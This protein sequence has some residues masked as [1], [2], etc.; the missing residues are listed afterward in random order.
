MAEQSKTGKSVAFVTLGCAKNEVDSEAM[1]SRLLAA[2]YE[3]AVSAEE[4][5]VVIVNTCS[6]IQA[7]T[8]ESI[9]AILEVAGFDSVVSGEAHLVVAGC[10]P[11]RYG[12][13]LADELVEASDFV[14]CADEGSIVET[15]DNLCGIDRI[16]GERRAI[17]SSRGV[18]SGV[19]AYVK[20]SDGC[21]RFCAY[22]T[23]PYIRG[24]YHSFTENEIDSEVQQ[25]VDSGTREIVL[26]AQDTGRWGQDFDEPSSLAD[27]L[28]RLSEKYPDTWFRVMYIQPEGVTDELIEAVRVHDNV[29]SYFDIPF[30]HCNADI[31][32]S[33]NRKGDAKGFLSLV[34]KIRERIPDVTLRTTLIA[35][36]PGETDEQ[37]EELCDFVEDADLDYVGVFAYSREEGTRA[38][39]LPDQVDD[40]EKLHR[41]QAIRDLADSLS[42]QR[43]SRRVG[44]R[45]DVLVCG[46]EEDGQLFGRAKC[47]APDVD[48]VTYVNEGSIGNIV[49]VLVEDTLAYEMEGSVLS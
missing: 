43:V 31:L 45:I 13:D 12:D 5:D 46:E 18:H 40:D 1:L 7:A 21:D 23:I 38:F 27:L 42:T 15:V 6:F 37:F 41:A 8:E 48:G 17:R 16:A 20:I 29:C 36:Y 44:Q 2:G 22:C 35:G 34:D 49:T 9:D 26:I 10:M 14:P 4:A 47:Q 28:S 19:S 30:Q 25:L 33:M 3:E 39:G 24:R 32:K 11:A